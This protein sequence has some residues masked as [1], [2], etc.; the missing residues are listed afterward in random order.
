[1]VK[2]GVDGAIVHEGC[3]AVCENECQDNR[4]LPRFQKQASME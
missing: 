2:S 3:E 4:P 1:M